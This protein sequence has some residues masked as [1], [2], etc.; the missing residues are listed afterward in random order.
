MPPN[1]ITIV[2]AE[3]DDG[4][5]S[6]ME[7]ARKSARLHRE[8]PMT[9]SL[10]D[11]RLLDGVIDLAFIENDTWIVVDFKTSADVGE[12]RPHYERQLQWYA[13]ALMQLTG[14]SAKSVLL[15][16]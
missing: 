13:F 1:A 7:R 3:D 2:L 12:R 15:A 14:I 16:V 11:A 4:H 8:Y 6:L 5:A 10:E 9:L